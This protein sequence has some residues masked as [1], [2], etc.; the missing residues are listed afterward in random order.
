M[1]PLG[2]YPAAVTPMGPDG[3][4]D[5]ESMAKLLAWFEAAGC[6]G[7]VLAGTNG[8][9]PSLSAVEKRDLLEAAMPW[10]GKLR[11]ILGIATPSLEEA[12]WLCRR[13]SDSGAEAALVMPPYYF[14]TA[15]PDAIV[16]WFLE[17]LDRSPI[18]VLIYNFPQNTGVVVQ[19]DM[20]EVIGRHERCAG[21]KDSSGNRD[22]LESYRASLGPDRVLFVG[23][24]TLLLDA[25]RAGWTGTISG[26]AN[27]IGR[28]LAAIV[29]DWTAGDSISA[30]EK[31]Q[32]ALPCI[33]ALR[34]RPQPALNKACLERIGI[35]ANR[36][37][38][39]PLESES[40]EQADS[41]LAA[42]EG[43]LG[44]LGRKNA[45]LVGERG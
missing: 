26:A 20:M 28:W 15:R 16:E 43:R 34:A 33:E 10:R 17:L 23:N 21:C 13:A 1:L 5:L 24:E 11:L 3:R 39:L 45:P 27:V 42:I 6:E 35:V 19:P 32:L 36:K 30:S 31:F 4:P 25:L 7:A 44:P 14:R 41:A 9:G 18:P 2:A 12:S 40:D 8:E 38:R 29:R 22:N 37:V